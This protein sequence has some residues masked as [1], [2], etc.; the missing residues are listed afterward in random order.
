MPPALARRLLGLVASGDRV[1]GLPA[2]RIAGRSVS[3]LRV[4]PADRDTTVGR[5]DVWADPRSGLPVEVRVTA[6]S[7]GRTS[8]T[9][10]FLDLRQ[11]RPAASA[12]AP[13]PA[14]GVTT[15]RVETLDLLS[16]LA[17]RTIERLPDDLAGRRAGS[18][19]ASIASVRAYS[20]GFSSFAVAP[21]PGRYGRRVFD[22]AESA[23]AG[24]VDVEGGEAVVMRTPV[25]TAMLVRGTGAFSTFLLV[26]AVRAEVLRDAG[27]ELIA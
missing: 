5:V 12:V 6:R 2:R 15:A 23:G 20:G 27:R 4:V 21:L 25:A 22:A 19:S 3:G 13:R 11:S 17:S 7:T 16:R 26:G 1:S 18:S 9:T 24:R 8:L 14:H 10:R